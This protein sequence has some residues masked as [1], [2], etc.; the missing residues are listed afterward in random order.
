MYSWK[1]I[2]KSLAALIAPVIAL[3]SLT[4]WLAGAEAFEPG[5]LA[6]AVATGVLAAVAVYFAPNELHPA[7][8]AKI[9]A[10]QASNGS[11]REV[12]DPAPTPP[13]FGDRT[14]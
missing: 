10:A 6:S 12:T 13:G 4:A 1:R 2:R 14:V 7:T 11:E 3:P 5:T 8:V 9:V